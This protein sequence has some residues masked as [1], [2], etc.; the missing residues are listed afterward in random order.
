M[1][2]GSSGA[3]AQNGAGLSPEAVTVPPELHGE[4]ADKILA[5]LVQR[6]T[7]ALVQRWLVEG[8]VAVGGKPLRGKERLSAGTKIEFFR[9]EELPTRAVPDETVPFRICFEDEAL[10]VV[11]KPAGIVVHPSRGHA[12]GTLVNGLLSHGGFEFDDEGDP[13]AGPLRHFRPGIVHRI[14][15]ETSGL[16]VV[17]KTAPVREALKAQFAVHTILRSYSALTY[18][19]PKL[20]RIETLFGR[21]K[22]SRIRF[23]TRVSQG[24]R[25]VTLVTRA[26]PL[27][28]GSAAYVECSLE[29]GRTHQIRVHL[30]EC[31]G[32]PLLADS[33]YRKPERGLDQRVVEV[34][35]NLGR[36]ALHARTLG[37]KHP[38]S[39]IDL[40]FEAPFP[41]DFEQALRSLQGLSA[42]AV[43]APRN[44][45]G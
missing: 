32:A 11:D 45:R 42:A 1:P 7:R 27:A 31:G 5:Q 3:P 12:G 38:L 18:G 44:R 26:D 13:S 25:A 21:D 24:K 9:G 30:T 4:R 35:D 17:A 36:Q 40:F 43:D 39:G 34:S 15:K 6:V 19:V 28:G 23:T 22:H 14:D 37:F 8:L 20:G 10:L 29:T 16:L 41:S 33:T 2:G